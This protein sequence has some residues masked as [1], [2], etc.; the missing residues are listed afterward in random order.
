[1]S[2]RKE[3]MAD[4]CS[5]TLHSGEPCGRV[6]TLH[7]FP[8]YISDP[9]NNVAPKGVIVIIPD[10]F[11][12]ELPNS[13]V[14]A[15]NYAK[16]LGCQVLLPEV[17]DGNRLDWSMLDPLNAMT[18]KTAGFMSKMYENCQVLPKAFPGGSFSPGICRDC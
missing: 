11:G 18:D 3:K 8:C 5:G 17:M 16:R 4:C 9:P 1:M 7:D 12:W 6:E 13:R 15:D 2:I 14:L 10:A